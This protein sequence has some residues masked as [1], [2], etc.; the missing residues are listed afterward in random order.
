MMK[1]VITNKMVITNKI[2]AVIT[3]RTKAIITE[4]LIT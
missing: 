2:E 4:G 1:A 3:Y